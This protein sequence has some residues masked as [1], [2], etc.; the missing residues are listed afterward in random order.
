M[1]LTIEDERM[2]LVVDGSNLKK[3]FYI[4]ILPHK[5]VSRI[6]Q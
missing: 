1:S 4:F 3:W 6:L 5:V 2:F